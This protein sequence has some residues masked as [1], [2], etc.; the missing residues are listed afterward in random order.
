MDNNVIQK[1]EEYVS[2]EIEILVSESWSPI[3]AGSNE[4]GEE[5]GDHP[6]PGTV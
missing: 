6:W 2:P 4:G 3:L 1:V 5:G